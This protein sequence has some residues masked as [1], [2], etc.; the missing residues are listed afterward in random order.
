MEGDDSK[1]TKHIG[2]FIDSK[3]VGVLSL[4]QT[5]TRELTEEN[6]YQLR[7]MAVAPEFQGLQI[8]KKLVIF[9]ENELK[10]MNVGLLWC[11]ARETAVQFYK[12]L[13]FEVISDVFHIPDVGPHY[14]MSKKLI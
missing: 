12:K 9:S 13:Q 1:S 3:C 4:F 10:K 5:K 6:Q 8:G 2:A 11:N 14:R 7:G